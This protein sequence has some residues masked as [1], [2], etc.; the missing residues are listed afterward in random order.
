ML[1]YGQMEELLNATQAELQRLLHVAEE[2]RLLWNA[3]VLATSQRLQSIKPME[4]VSECTE[5][6]WDE[7]KSSGANRSKSEISDWSDEGTG[8]AVMPASDVRRYQSTASGP[9]SEPSQRPLAA[10]EELVDCVP[11]I[12]AETSPKRRST[13]SN[14]SDASGRARGAKSSSRRSSEG[15][16]ASSSQQVRKSPSHGSEASHVSDGSEASNVSD[17]SVASDA[18]DVSYVEDSTETKS[19]RRKRGR[20]SCDKK[21]AKDNTLGLLMNENQPKKQPTSQ[22]HKIGIKVTKHLDHIAGAL[23]LLNSLSMM[24]QLEMEGRTIASQLG[25]PEGHNFTAALPT[26]R[27]VDTIFV[28]VFLAELL[29]RMVVEGCHFVKDIANWLDSILVAGGLI[30]FILATVGG[31]QQDAATL[32]LIA[33]MKAFRAIRMVRSFRFSPGLRMLVKACQ[34]CLPSLCWSMLLLAVF[35][36]MGAL[37][38]GNLLQD[39]ITDENNLIEDREWIWK[40]YGTT[41]RAIYTLYEITFAGNW[42]SN[43]RPVLDKVSQMFVIFYLLYV[44]IIVFAVIRVISAIFLKDTLDEANNDAHQIVLDRLRKKAEYVDRLEQTFHSIDNSED[45]V[46]TEARL[47]EALANPKVKAYFATLEID[48]QEGAVLFHLLDNGDGEVTLDEFISGVMR[49]KGPAKAIDTFALQRDLGKLDHKISK[50]VGKLEEVQAAS[51]FKAAQYDRHITPLASDLMMGLGGVGSV[52]S[53]SL[54]SKQPAWAQVGAGSPVLV[55]NQS[56]TTSTQLGLLVKTP[57]TKTPERK[58]SV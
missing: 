51:P 46:L 57:D 58:V 30:D 10:A 34:C 14:R 32:R 8:A 47:T 52:P 7:S 37:I 19:K 23:V 13:R 56:P 53:S 42:P 15:A 45:G 27:T 41:Y 33:A 50:L 17:G 39:Y 16:G 54:P 40:R 11:S 43:A 26:F 5:E 31:G 24:I 25:F 6:R 55:A 20:R 49:C 22:W 3:E 21:K 4:V 28:W 12:E 9:Q 18:S 38:M 36:C 29:V 44:T 35:M 2:Q 48:V 1:P